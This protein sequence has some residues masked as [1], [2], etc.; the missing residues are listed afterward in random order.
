MILLKDGYKQI[1]STKDRFI[2]A[3]NEGRIESFI[4]EVVCLSRVED[5]LMMG[6]LNLKYIEILV[7]RDYPPI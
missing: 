3:I 1:I 4:K 7:E 2:N 5:G 6:E